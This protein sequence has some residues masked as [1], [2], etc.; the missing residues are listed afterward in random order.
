M[1]AFRRPNDS[2]LGDWIG[3][4]MRLSFRPEPMSTYLRTGLWH[5]EPDPTSFRIRLIRVGHVRD[6]SASRRLLSSWCPPYSGMALLRGRFP[7]GRRFRRTKAKY[8]TLRGTRASNAEPAA[9]RCRSQQRSFFLRSL[10]SVHAENAWYYNQHFLGR[11]GN[12]TAFL[13]TCSSGPNVGMQF[14]LKVFHKISD[15]TRR[16]AFLK[17]IVHLKSLDHPAITRIFD[18][19]TFTS[20]A[21]ANYP[22]A[23]ME[24]VPLTA[25]A[26]IVSKQIDRLRA[27]RIAFNCLSAINCLHAA[28]PPLIHRDI[29]PENILISETGAKLAD[30][31]LVKVLADLE[32]ENEADAFE[33]TQ[34]P[35]MPWRYRTPEL[36]QRASDHKTQI[37]SKTDIYQF[38]TVFYELLTG[39]NPQ[40]QPNKV[41]GSIELDLR[42]IKGSQGQDLF[43]LV[44]E[45]LAAKAS[46]RPPAKAC[47]SRLNKIHEAYC[48]SLF[49]VTGEYV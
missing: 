42:E 13:V 37:N 24:Y 47:L 19:G 46:N 35:G 28:S 17:E 22:F 11:G 36:V 15:A 1:L 32:P 3:H 34:W 45:M 29:K 43:E 16:K 38:G 48:R 49:D 39:F 20:Q 25:R 31:G 41:T 23:V 12:G 26:L 33:G 7:D 14:V 2:D 10:T 40:P 44:K 5:A 6:I 4:R 30:F 21:G 8:S 27:I 18:E 9:S